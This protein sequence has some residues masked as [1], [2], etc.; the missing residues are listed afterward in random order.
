MPS[1]QLNI[2]AEKDFKKVCNPKTKCKN[3]D[4]FL[5]QIFVFRKEYDIY[6]IELSK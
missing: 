1:V 6:R 2:D 4:D 5:A 3:L